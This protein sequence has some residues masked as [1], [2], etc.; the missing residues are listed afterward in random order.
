MVIIHL[1]SLMKLLSLPGFMKFL[2]PGFINSYVCMRFI[3]KKEGNYLAKY[4]FHQWSRDFVVRINDFDNAEEVK[5]DLHDTLLKLEQIYNEEHH[6][7][8]TG[9]HNIMSIFKIDNFIKIH[10]I[11]NMCDCC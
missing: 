2:L 8:N 7:F 3:H 9:E 11:V 1:F 4:S 5:Q 10:V 6:A